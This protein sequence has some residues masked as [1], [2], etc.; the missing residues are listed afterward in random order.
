M[1]LVTKRKWDNVAR[2]YD[3]MNGFGPEWRW[4]PFKRRLFSMMWGKVLFAAVGTGQDIQFFPTGPGHRRDRHQRSD[5]GCCAAASG[6]VSRQARAQTPGCARARLSR[7]HL[8]PGVHVVHV[9]LGAAPGRRL[10]LGPTGAQTGRTAA[11]VRTHW[12]PLPSVQ[13]DVEPHQPH[14]TPVWS[15]SQPGHR[16]QTSPR[17]G[18]RSEPSSMSISTW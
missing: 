3:L 4:D 13:R 2:G 15:R 1:D 18:S 16:G 17:P 6:R 5:A 7:R 9:L 12:Q 8:R 14:R 10:D 11:Y